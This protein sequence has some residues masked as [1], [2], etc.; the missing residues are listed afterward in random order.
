[1][2]A[3]GVKPDRRAWTALI[4]AHAA[5]G[6]LRSAADAYWRM[7]DAGVV[8]DEATLS[9][10]LAAGPARDG[11]RMDAAAAMALYRDARALDVRPNNEGFRRLTGIWVDQAFD[12]SNG[13]SAELP[14]RG[15]RTDS[16]V[17]PER[18]RS[19]ETTETAETI[20]TF[21]TDAETGDA[22]KTA[23]PRTTAPDFML[24][25]LVD[26]DAEARRGDDEKGSPRDE[27]NASNSNRRP[28]VDVHGLSTVET[29]AAVLSVLQALRE[30]R[31]ARLAVSG[32]LVIV[33]GSPRARK[34]KHSAA[35]I[36]QRGSVL[37]GGVLSET[38]LRDAVKGLAKDLDL[39]V[40]DV[41]Q[42]AGRLV[43]RER[44][45]LKWLDRDR[46]AARR[47]AA[48]PERAAE[49]TAA[50]RTAVERTEKP[51]DDDDDDDASKPAAS[52]PRRRRASRRRSKSRDVPGLEGALKEWLRENDSAEID[53]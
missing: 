32:D 2:Q 33:T 36:E 1:M 30:R 5:G 50:E 47:G 14:A 13:A 24:A 31:R 18:G 45:L 28:L 15:A 9:A 37:G 23:R 21:V 43:I 42:N 25:S 34:S 11:V 41:E 52:L 38:S 17:S 27:K 3:M 49:R 46:A 35:G 44:E 7:R 51:R 6:D 22:G 48:V 10:A 19:T 12:G 8:P 4:K 20:P 40:E 26:D 39:V 29:R 53:P 16:A